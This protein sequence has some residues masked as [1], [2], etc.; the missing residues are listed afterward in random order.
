M[1]RTAALSTG[2]VLTLAAFG[3]GGGEEAETEAPAEAPPAEAPA[4]AAAAGMPEWYQVDHTAR[5][6][7]LTVTAGLDATNNNWNFNGG[8]NGNVTITVPEGYTVNMTFTNR[9]AAMAHSV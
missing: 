1:R 3:C 2:L 6:V 8:A 5:T 4:P 9:D 7:N